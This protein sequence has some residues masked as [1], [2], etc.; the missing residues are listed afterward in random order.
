MSNFAFSVKCPEHA[1]QQNTHIPS[2]APQFFHHTV[3]VGV[4]IGHPNVL[5]FDRSLSLSF[6]P[7]VRDQ[8]F[9]TKEVHHITNVIHVNKS[10]S[11]EDVTKTLE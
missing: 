8:E 4:L 6:Y 7:Q 5:T 1:E 9:D 2:N 11:A 3:W 10:L